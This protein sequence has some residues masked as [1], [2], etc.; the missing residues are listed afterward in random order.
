[1]LGMRVSQSLY[2]VVDLIASEVALP[3]WLAGPEGPVQVCWEY[4][5]R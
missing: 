3:S 2:C 5:S 1:M 4:Y